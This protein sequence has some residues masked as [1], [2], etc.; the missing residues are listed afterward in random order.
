MISDRITHTMAFITSV[1]EIR[2]E[3][4]KAQWVDQVVSVGSSTTS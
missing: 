4:E 1:L 2:L 3:Q